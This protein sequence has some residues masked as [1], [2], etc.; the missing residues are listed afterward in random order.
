MQAAAGRACFLFVPKELGDW[1]AEQAAE[2][3][4][5]CI[6]VKLASGVP[7]MASLVCILGVDLS[8]CDNG[9]DGP[10]LLAVS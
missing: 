1:R 8:R 4:V 3:S 6:S 10:W 2:R 9:C 7:S 5:S